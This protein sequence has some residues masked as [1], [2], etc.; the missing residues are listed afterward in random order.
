MHRLVV[1]PDTPQA[2]ELQL[3]PGPNQIGRETEN[4]F[5]INHPSISGAHCQIIVEGGVVRLTDLGSS[6]GTFVNS[7]QVDEATLRSGDHVQLGAVDMIFQSVDAAEAAPIDAASPLLTAEEPPIPLPIAVL[8]VAD[9]FCKFHPKSPAHYFCR[10][11]N[12]YFC[13]LCVNTRQT[14]G[15]GAARFCR[16]CGIAC[17]PVRAHVS[18]DTQPKDFYSQ[19][20]GAFAYPFKGDGV[21]LLIA[22]TIFYVV[23]SYAQR[24]AGYAG[25]FGLGGL[26]LLTL[27]ATGYMV[28]Y[29]ESMLKTSAMGE[30]KM[31]DWPDFTDFGT[32]IVAP[33]LQFFGTVLTCFAPA[34]AV[35]FFVPWDEPLKWLYSLAALVLG[36]ASFPMAFLAV[37]MFDSIGA[38]NPLLLVPSMLRVPLQYLV[39]IA[40]FEA[41]FLANR[42]ALTP[43]SMVLPI[44]VVPEIIRIFASLYLTAVLMRILGLLYLTNKES[45]GWFNR[46]V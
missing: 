45:L 19:L 10:K 43:L 16:T 36:V 37:T 18:K 46:A 29:M 22:G 11:C 7:A 5:Q 42:H 4:D 44:P 2:W 13:E 9:A 23:V 21:F 6:N 27:F 8:S 17:A 31:P 30:E 24:L 26:L 41:M 25:L 33:F 35:G 40:I 15:G 3:K 14:S 38:L 39:T 1:N 28:A 12:K 20:P 32:D 34:I